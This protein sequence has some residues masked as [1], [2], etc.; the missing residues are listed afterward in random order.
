MGTIFDFS[1]MTYPLRHPLCW[2]LAQG[3]IAESRDNLVADLPR[4]EDTGHVFQ[5]KHLLDPFPLRAEPV[6]EIGA[7]SDQLKTFSKGC[8]VFCDKSRS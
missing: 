3:K 4:L 7:T 5:A 6:I 8:F 2:H 1:T